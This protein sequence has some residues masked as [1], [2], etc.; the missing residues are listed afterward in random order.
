MSGILAKTGDAWKVKIEKA[1]Q[2]KHPITT[3]TTPTTT[4]ID[5]SYYDYFN[6]YYCYYDYLQL[7]TLL[8]RTASLLL[9]HA[10]ATA[11]ATVATK[12][13][14]NSKLKFVCWLI[15]FFV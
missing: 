1:D 7:T 2:M 6:Y 5:Y 13:T 12:Q 9:R 11:T 15:E 3:T 4:S 10:T 14:N 8:L